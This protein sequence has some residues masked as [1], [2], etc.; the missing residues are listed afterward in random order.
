MTT[1]DQNKKTLRHFQCR[2]YLW[3]IFEQMST[4]LECSTD[5]LINEAMRQYARSRNYGTARSGTQ[6]PPSDAPPRTDTP[7]MPPADNAAYAA[8]ASGIPS[9]RD[10]ASQRGGALPSPPPPRARTT[11]AAGGAVTVPVPVKPPATPV[12]P[13]KRP[14]QSSL[15]PPPPPPPPPPGARTTGRGGAPAVTNPPPLP[16]GAARPPAVN[17]A[18]ARSL[19]IIFNGQKIPV[20]KEEFVIGRGSKSADLAIKDGNIS[21]RHAAVVLHNGAYYLKD[22]GSTNGVEFQGRRFDSKR[23]DEGDL[24]RICDY[25]LRFTYQ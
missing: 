12:S 13:P 14:S 6:E 8:A 19:Y 20:T 15:P 1:H 7:L 3:D 5:Y 25:E 23:I 9:L 24:F 11:T 2:D 17:N 18:R 10:T 4:E 22:L 16:G 21:R